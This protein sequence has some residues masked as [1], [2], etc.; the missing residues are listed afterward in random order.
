MIGRYTSAVCIT[1][2]KKK[3]ERNPQKEGNLDRVVLTARSRGLENM[4]L[5]T[6]ISPVERALFLLYILCFSFRK[7]NRGLQMHICFERCYS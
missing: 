7:G 6:R 4:I 1:Q 2:A 3:E 5:N